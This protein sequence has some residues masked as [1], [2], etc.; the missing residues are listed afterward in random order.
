MQRKLPGAIR[1]RA[2][3]ARRVQAQRLRCTRLLTTAPA[4]ERGVAVQRIE[5]ILSR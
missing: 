3:A 2:A 5:R 4:T 1:E